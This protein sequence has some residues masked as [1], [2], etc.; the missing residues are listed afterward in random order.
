MAQP[1]AGTM[2][3]K[4]IF[5]TIGRARCAC[6]ESKEDNGALRD[7][8]RPKS[9]VKQGHHAKPGFAEKIP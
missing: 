1:K 8:D 3:E 7:D 5:M 6:A 9:P 4:R 2:V